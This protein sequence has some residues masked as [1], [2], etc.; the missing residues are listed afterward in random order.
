MCDAGLCRDAYIE[1]RTSLIRV[2]AGTA[3]MFVLGVLSLAGVA[4]G[5]GPY[6]SCP[7]SRPGATTHT[8]SLLFVSRLRVSGM[9]CVRATAAVRAGAFELTPAGPLFHTRGFRCTSPIGPPRNLRPRYFHCQRASRAF[10]F[11]LA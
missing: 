4:S 5:A 10:E 9:S 7:G 2:G 11:T 3:L 6:R 1:V 8:G